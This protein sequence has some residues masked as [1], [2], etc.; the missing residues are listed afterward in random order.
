VSTVPFAHQ[1]DRLAPEGRSP[2]DRRHPHVHEGVR[3]Q[4]RPVHVRAAQQLLGLALRG[5]ERNRVVRRG[6][7]HGHEHEPTN[8]RM[9]GC[10]DQAMVAAAIH[11]L[12]R[13]VPAAPGGVGGRHY[14]VDVLAGADQRIGVLQIT[15]DTLHRPAFAPPRL[16]RSNQDADA[17]TAVALQQEPR[18][19]PAQQSRAS[20]HED[21]RD[22]SSPLTS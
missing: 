1:D 9:R 15:A 10:L 11:G 19:A 6:A 21:H 2:D 5:H 17:L 7:Q 8:P 13:V 14:G 20:H 18:D 16:L 12:D 22:L 3:L 4:D